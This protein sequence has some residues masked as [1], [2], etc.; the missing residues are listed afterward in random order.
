MPRRALASKNDS[1]AQADY[2]R[3][4]I[5]DCENRHEARGLCNKHYLRLS[6]NG[7][8]LAGRGFDGASSAFFA[9]A[10]LQFVGDECLPW[11]FIRDRNGYGVFYHKGRKAFVHRVACEAIHGCAP[12]AKHEAAHSCGKGHEGCVNPRHLRWATPSENQADRIAHGTHCRGSR[13]KNA[14]LTELEAAQVLA[15]KG[16]LSQR[17]IAKRFG[18]SAATI[19]AI[20]ERRRWKHILHDSHTS[21]H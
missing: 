4:S 7:D 15:L 13:S 3:C 21:P 14:K 18:V 16:Q 9:T 17:S 12:T 19:Q 10:V 6:R 5:E 8:P 11:P 2:R 20:H 1:T